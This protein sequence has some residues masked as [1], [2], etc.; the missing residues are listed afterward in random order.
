MASSLV[1]N[2]ID[3]ATQKYTQQLDLLVSYGY[4]V[5][6]L[7]KAFY[8]IFQDEVDFIFFLRER[9]TVVAADLRFR[10]VYRP[11][12]A[13]LGIR[14]GVDYTCDLRNY[15]GSARRLSA[16]VTVPLVMDP[17]AAPPHISRELF[18]NWHGRLAGIVPIPSNTPMGWADN[19]VNGIAGGFD[20]TTIK[21]LKGNP[22]AD[23]MSLVPGSAYFIS[24]FNGYSSKIDQ[25]FAPFELWLMGLIG[26]EEVP[27]LYGR[28]PGYSYARDATG[29]L[30]V[31]SNGFT[32]ITADDIIA[33]NGG[34]PPRAQSTTFRAAWVVVSET[35][36]SPEVMAKAEQYARIYG[37][38]ETHVPA[39]GQ[40]RWL[41]FAEAT[42]NKATLD[43]SLP[44]TVPPLPA[45]APPEV[46]IPNEVTMQTHPNQRFITLTVPQT[47][48]DGWATGKYNQTFSNVAKFTKPLYEKFKD[49]FDFVMFVLDLDNVPLGMPYGMH[50]AVSNQ[51][52]GIGKDISDNSAFYGSSGRLKGHVTMWM[53]TAMENGPFLHEICHQWANH[54]L[55]TEQY[56]FTT[57]KGAPEGK[58]AGGHWG[59]SGCGGQ[60]GG[61]DQ[62]TLQE[63][64]GVYSAKMGSKA[65]FGINANGGNSV[66]YSNFEL[67]LMGLIPD[68]EITPFDVFTGIDVSSCTKQVLL[69]NGTTTNVWDGSRFKA[70]TR[71]QYDKLSIVKELGPRVPSCENSQKTLNCLIVVLTTAQALSAEKQKEIDTML[72]RQ[73]YPGDSGNDYSYNFYEATG[74]RGRMSFDLSTSRREPGLPP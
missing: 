14:D 5:S 11:P 50:C 70:A 2:L 64:A 48:F 31:K 3:T 13:A 56:A 36:A 15:H 40:A 53:R 17:A 73:S 45:Q 8:D 61:F 62:S 6:T 4:D 42:G 20:Q 69:M 43:G 72:A 71:T 34:A 18:R 51:V 63:N 33:A 1:Y 74:G 66:P 12:C 28:Q 22:I 24:S 58:G 7:T 26:K 52:Q 49:D 10:D 41:S 57:L 21:D 68:T 59:F 47:L 30:Y 16:V 65:T 29:K 23:P 60:L 44:Q 37:G 19:S 46:L 39:A 27:P 67:Y 38:L 9:A 32:M 35:A 54:A 25:K 55:K